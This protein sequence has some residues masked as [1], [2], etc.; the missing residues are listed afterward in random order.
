MRIWLAR[1][2]KVTIRDQLVTQIILGIL[3]KD[4]APRERLPST[5]SLARRFGVHAN[6][7]SAA[8]RHL[9]DEQWV[10]SRRGSGIYVREAPPERPPSNAMELDQLIRQFLRSARK[11]GVPLESVRDRVQ[12]WFQ[13]Q[14]PD[15]F[16]LIEPDREL[17]QILAAEMQSVVRLAVEGC[18]PGEVKAELLNGAVPVA[19]TRT[20]EQLRKSLLR[21]TEILTLDLRSVTGSLAGWLPAPPTA[22]VGVASHWPRFLKLARTVLLAAGISPECVLLRDVRKMSGMRG[23]Q[24]TAVVVCDSVTAKKMPTRFRTVVFR[25]I[26]EDSLADLRKYEAFLN[27]E[28]TE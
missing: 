15:H 26:A 16:L 22:L 21:D 9:E 2:S 1:R 14:P 23:L 27:G 17:R 8:Y 7:I 10:E 6:T 24:E 11:L 12:H 28:S 13:L 4:L 3:G 25:L 18:G 20:A 5:R 19:L